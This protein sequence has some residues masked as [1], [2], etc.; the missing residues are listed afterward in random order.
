MAWPQPRQLFLHRSLI[1]GNSDYA[2]G[3]LPFKRKKGAL[4]GFT[5]VSVADGTGPWPT[6]SEDY[7]WQVLIPWGEPLQPYGPSFSWP[8]TAAQQEQ[9]IGIGHDGMT[10]FPL[11]RKKAFDDDDYKRFRG[12]R[13]GNSHGLLAINHEFGRNPHVLGKSAPESLEDVRTSQHAH[14]CICC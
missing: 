3:E 12:S 14:A 1:A 9:Q 5:P 11:S 4:I 8:P 7:E 10:F 6:I 13:K 2:K